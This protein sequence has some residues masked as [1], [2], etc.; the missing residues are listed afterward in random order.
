MCINACE[1]NYVCMHISVNV[2]FSTLCVCIYMCV[3]VGLVTVCVCVG[4]DRIESVYVGRNK[5][6]CLCK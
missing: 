2:Y 4:E 6:M 5:Y 1:N 3:Y